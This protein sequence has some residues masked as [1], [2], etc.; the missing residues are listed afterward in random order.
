MGEDDFRSLYEQMSPR[1]YSFAAR[2]LSPEVAGD[3]VSETFEVAWS[4]RHEWPSESDARAGWVFTIGKNKILQESQRIR[5][6]H[7]DNRFAADYATRPA[8][9]SDVAETVTEGA[10]GQAVYAQLTEA[11][12]ELFDIA[13]MRDLGRAEGAAILGLSVITFT[14]RVSRL[15]R[16]IESLQ[17]ASTSDGRTS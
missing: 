8:V 15:R 11:E 6:K 3:I 17:H 5:R 13:F 4:K 12:A 2:R 16:R 7:H 9:E 10:A 14:T 1:I